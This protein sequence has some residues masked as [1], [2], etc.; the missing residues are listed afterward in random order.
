MMKEIPIILRSLFVLFLF[1]YNSSYSQQVFIDAK[2]PY[3]PL[4][5]A[6]PAEKNIRKPSDLLKIFMIQDGKE[7]DTPLLGTY[8]TAEDT[9]F[10][11]PQ[12]ELGEGLSFS[13]HF[14]YKNDTLKNLYKTPSINHNISD[15][16]IIKKV[17]PRS[18][19]IPKNILT[20]YVEFSEPMMED[21][22]AFRYI[23]LYNENNEIVP[24]PWLHKSRWITNK[25]L[26]VMIHP[27]RIKK[28]I[29]YYDNL[30][31]VFDTGKKYHLEITDNIKPLHKN[32]IVKP[33]IKEFE[34][35]EAVESC[36]KILRNKINRPKK[37][38]REKLKILFN[39]SMDLYSILGGISIKKHKNDLNIEGQIL[40][41]P[42]DKEWYFVP[43][44]PW[45]GEKY[46]LILNKYVSDPSGNGII[47]PFETLKIKKSYT[48]DIVKR[49]NFRPE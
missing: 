39:R 48:K 20:F 37:N 41:G 28:G 24:Y 34:I 1:L 12:F 23:N 15:E 3:K 44:K 21:G 17:F 6:S 31:N 45:K 22:S 18:H 49:I 32:A 27:G 46:T 5:K 30:G 29:S 14:Y 26:M 43:D 33:F 35:T 13:V 47:K 42:D 38:T 2:K 36:P 19:E 8:S 11:E 25:I 16:I 40:P 7:S 4:F 9:I 10:F